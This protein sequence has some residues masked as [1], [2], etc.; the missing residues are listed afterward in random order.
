MIY[1]TGRVIYIIHMMRMMV[2]ITILI[3]II[4][5]FILIVTFI[6]RVI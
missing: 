5:V 2:S 3:V 4:F 1:L 6:N